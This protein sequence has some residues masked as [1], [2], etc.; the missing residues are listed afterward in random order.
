MPVEACDRTTAQQFPWPQFSH[1]PK[2]V[3]PNEAVATGVLCYLNQGALGRNSPALALPRLPGRGALAAP[4]TFVHRGAEGR[5]WRVS[6]WG[7]AVLNILTLSI[8]CCAPA[9]NPSISGS[10]PK[11]SG[12][13]VPYSTHNA[14]GPD[15]APGAPGLWFSLRVEA[16]SHRGSHTAS[17]WGD[18]TRGLNTG[19][20]GFPASPGVM[21]H[22]PWG[23]C[24]P[25]PPPP[26]PPHPPRLCPSWGPRS[27][28]ALA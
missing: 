13:R 12:F 11:G 16:G 7:N 18:A 17:D 25:T 9:G 24:S 28:E 22:G 10:A 14:G 26:P 23:C 19:R 4:L 20:D 1:P 6:H 21:V 5:A 15:G 8:P 2:W 3:R 27:P